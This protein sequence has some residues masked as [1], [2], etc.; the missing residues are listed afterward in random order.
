MYKKAGGTIPVIVWQSQLTRLQYLNSA[1]NASNV[2]VQIWANAKYPQ[3]I[4]ILENDFKIVLSNFDGLYLDCGVG[5]WNTNGQVNWC[6]PY[7]TWQNIYN[8]TPE[9]VTGKYTISKIE[10]PLKKLH[11]FQVV[12]KIK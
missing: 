7:K 2:Y 4:Q 9:A 6:S 8:N 5:D 12:E 11:I 1:Y 10:I 3:N